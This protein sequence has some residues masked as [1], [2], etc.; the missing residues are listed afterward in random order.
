[1]RLAVLFVTLLGLGGLFT[2]SG[3]GGVTTAGYENI[4][5]DDS[6]ACVASRSAAFKELVDDKQ[7]AWVNRPAS[8]SLHASGVRMFAFKATKGQLTCAQLTAGINE[9]SSVPGAL[10]GSMPGVSKDRITQAKALAEET[11]GELQKVR[12]SK[13]CA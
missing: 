8:R 5:L 9:A 4:C 7:H 10:A 6:G 1:M 13:R 11:R 3:C 12:T 2:L